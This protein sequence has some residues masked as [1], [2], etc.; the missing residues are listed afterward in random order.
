M[1]DNDNDDWL[2]EDGEDESTSN[3]ANRWTIL[4]VDDEPDIHHV[5]RL[6]LANIEF[7]GRQLEILSCYSGAESLELL[8][9]RNDIALVLLDV[10]MEQEDS[11][12]QVAHAI[13]ETLGN[14]QIR[15]ILRTGQPGVAPERHVIESY[16]INDYKAKTELTRDKLYT[17]ILGTL[18]SYKDIMLLEHQRQ[19]LDANRRGL[20]KVI[21]ASANI[22]KQQSIQNFAQGVLEQLQSLLFFE[23]EALYIV[24]QGGMAAL[25]QDGEIQVMYA[26][27]GYQALC[28]RK[29]EYSELAKFDASI[30]LAMHDE[31][32]IYAADHFVGF[33][34]AEHGPVNLLIIDG[35]VALSNPDKELIELFCRNVSIAFENL[36]MN[37]EIQALRGAE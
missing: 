30:K 18:R 7:L 33:F 3:N 35:P 25:S 26:T 8:R 28:G 23:Q 6:A 12:L 27:G 21:E 22:F 15:I 1:N 11:G 19:M 17:A 29:L 36:I 4:V 34:H 37:K 13:R 31:S 10:V 16:D 14:H 20:I 32:S 24:V 5:T 9:S 2:D